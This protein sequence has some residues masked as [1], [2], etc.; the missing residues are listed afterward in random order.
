MGD[1]NDEIE[2]ARHQLSG[3]IDSWDDA[4]LTLSA[5]NTGALSAIHGLFGP[6][7]T[8]D[9][10]AGGTCSSERKKPVRTK[11]MVARGS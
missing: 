7:S 11:V 5:Y 3:L 8:E 4:A 9:D 6:D 10:Q 1:F 2:K